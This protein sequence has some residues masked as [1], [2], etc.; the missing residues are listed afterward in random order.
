[1]SKKPNIILITIDCLR[2]DYCGWLNPERAELT[3][4]LNKLAK[5][6]LVFTQAYATGPFTQLAMPAILTGT[7]TLILKTWDGKAIAGIKEKPYL[8]E[9]LHNNGYFTIAI[10]DNPILSSFYGFD[11]GFD[12]FKDLGSSDYKFR[13]AKQQSLKTR[14]GIKKLQLLFLK[15]LN[16]TKWYKI[17][18]NYI[19]KK[20]PTLYDFLKFIAYQILPIKPDLFLLTATAEKI[21]KTVFKKIKFSKD[22]LFLWIHYMD[23]HAPYSLPNL[24]KEISFPLFSA[25]EIEY[26]NK[27]YKKC[28]FYKDSFRGEDEL[29]KK[30]YQLN[31]RYLDWQIEILFEKLKNELK[32]SIIIITADHGDEFNEH[33]D[34]GHTPTKENNKLFKE[35]LL[36]PLLL[37]TPNKNKKIIDKIVSSSQI[38]ATILE[39]AKIKIPPR[40]EPSLFTKNKVR[41]YAESISFSFSLSGID[42]TKIKKIEIK[43]A[44][45]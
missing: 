8:P 7:Y 32:N 6:N 13:D 3:P 43:K 1:M 45:L 28:S 2:A 38:P 12:I 31:L 9:I 16:Q 11:R 22:P 40:M 29:F 14:F 25:K 34:W 35:L 20:T 19:F 42:S 4:F 24:P 39:L 41:V 21:N 18:R 10:H 26:L 33:G 5:E 23:T 30:V 37:I 27:K 17:I 15:K 44:Q 36:V